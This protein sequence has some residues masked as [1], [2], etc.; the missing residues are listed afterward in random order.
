MARKRSSYL[1]RA[2]G[3]LVLLATLGAIV[4]AWLP[5]PVPVE[6]A[7][8]T[9]GRLSVTVD[10]DGRTRVKDRYVVSAP[11]LAKLSRIEL[12]AGDP[13]AE[14]Q[15]LARL[16]PLDPPMLDTRSRAQAVAR[17]AGS[18]AAQR[19]A[20]VEVQRARSALQFARQQAARQRALGRTGASSAQLAEQAE[21]EE[22]TAR[23]ALA[24]AEF[25]ARV[26]KYELQMAELAVGRGQER[27]QEH[28]QIEVASPVQGQVLRVIQESAAVVQPATPLL[29]IGDLA[30]LEIVADVLTS[31]ALHIR[32]GARAFVE[33]WGEGQPLAARVRRVEPSAFTRISTLGVEEQRVNVIL[34]LDAPRSQ[35]SALGDGFRV[36]IRIEIWSGE[37]VLTVPTSAVFRDQNRWSAYVVDE[38]GTARLVRL[39]LGHRGRDRVEVRRGLAEGARVIVHPGDRVQD[40]TRVKRR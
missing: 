5:D 21:L 20:Q 9:R 33:R 40:G 35:W 11:L 10:E 14:G 3:V 8:A 15:P 13:V 27:G 18:A 17:V 24:S 25:A 39:E 37:G 30:A 23:D 38:D 2:L 4:L 16:V 32:K 26:A 31:D 6:I 28:E 29:E 22:R 34:D 1:K 12:E 7:Q 36:E 19:Q